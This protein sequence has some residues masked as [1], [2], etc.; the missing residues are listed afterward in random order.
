MV[1]TR[2]LAAL[3]NHARERD[4]K[5][6]LVG[7]DRQLPEIEAGG[8]FRALAER[9]GALELRDVRRQEEAWDRDALGEL[10]NGDVRAWARAYADE[11]RL[12]TAPTVPA[13]RERLAADWWE[14][15]KQGDDALM[16]ALRRRDVADLNQRGRERMRDAGRLAEKVEIGERA[17]A[18]GDRAVLGRNDRHLDVVKGDRGEITA[19][20]DTHV[21]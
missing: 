2:D 15:R 17:Y 9:E 6:V 5:L 7:D 10:R 21:D 12:V 8:A 20:S 14:A 1:G 4:A 13:L 18:V 11:D 16:V 3:A 19:T